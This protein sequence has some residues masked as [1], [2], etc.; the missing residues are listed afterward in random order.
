MKK[1]I[2]RKIIVTALALM[3]AAAFVFTGASPVSAAAPRP[4]YIIDA[5]MS[6]V[7]GYD[8]AE[9]G[10]LNFGSIN[11]IGTLRN[12][13][14]RAWPGE[15]NRWG[16]DGCWGGTYANTLTI[17]NGAGITGGGKALLLNLKN[18]GDRIYM[19]INAG[20]DPGKLKIE[21]DNRYELSFNFKNKGDHR[22][23]LDPIMSI[24]SWSS[25]WWHDGHFFDLGIP[26]EQPYEWREYKIELYY[27]QVGSNYRLDVSYIFTD[28]NGQ[29]KKIEYKANTAHPATPDGQEGTKG[30][31]ILQSN[32]AIEGVIYFGFIIHDQTHYWGGRHENNQPKVPVDALFYCDSV[33]LKD[34][35]YIESPANYNVTFDPN[36]GA[37]PAGTAGLHN[38][39]VVK[40][41]EAGGNVTAPATNPIRSEYVFEGW[42]SSTGGSIE[43]GFNNIND[44]KTAY[45]KWV[46][47]GDIPPPPSGNT[48]TV[49]FDPNGGSFAASAGVVQDGKLIISVTSG[50]KVSKPSNPV[51]YGYKLDNWYTKDGSGDD[52]GTL[53]SFSGTGANNTINADVTYYAKWVIDTSIKFNV[54]FVYNAEGK[55]P[56]TIQVVN[57]MAME[58]P[59]KPVREGYTFEGWHTDEELT[60]LWDFAYTVDGNLILY[61]SW[62]KSNA[63]CGCNKNTITDFGGGFGMTGLLML[64]FGAFV[65]MRIFIVGKTKDRQNNQLRRGL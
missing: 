6:D 62:E 13:N 57:G 37:F 8:T 65:V 32:Q 59:E 64:A 61:A 22:I 49:T 24:P 45:A 58:A 39:K 33:F 5:D 53:L 14:E 46:K 25:D 42:Y 44:N 10:Y 54:T 51:N 47:E 63:G 48:C 12:T 55:E 17:E 52:W 16:L 1:N 2:Q 56:L 21:P 7:S 31:C 36:G 30:N 20:A 35:N 11:K 29:Q 43:F 9:N 50:N 18:S 40:T 15:G 3:F 19:Q 34:M 28:V 27:H 60:V 4:G 41:V 23:R 38:G 26:E